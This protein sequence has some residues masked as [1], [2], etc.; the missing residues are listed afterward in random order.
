MGNLCTTIG[1]VCDQF[2]LTPRAVRFYEEA[3][4]IVATRDKWNKRVFDAANRDRLAMIAV[5]RRAGLGL[6]Q[7]AAILETEADGPEAQRAAAVRQLEL[8]IAH[9]EADRRK[10]EE[11]LQEIAPGRVAEVGRKRLR[12]V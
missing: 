11:A 6:P 5:Y 9:L 10:V 1:I 4:L 3:G 7:I 8:R 2:G 12:A